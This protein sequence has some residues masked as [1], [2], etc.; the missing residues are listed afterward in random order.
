MIVIG[1]QDFAKVHKALGH[2]PEK[3]R[4]AV[5][6]SINSAVRKGRTTIGKEIRNVYTVSRGR[7]YEGLSMS[8]ASPGNLHGSLVAKGE[9]IPIKEFKVKPKGPQPRSRPVITV[10]I[11][12][13]AAKPFPGGFVIGAFGSHVFTRK[14]RGR[15]PIEKRRSVSV[16]QMMGGDRAG[17]TIRTTIVEHYHKEAGRQ[18]ARALAK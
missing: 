16:P 10:E 14:G 5:S 17:E 15:F 18:V 3:A 4:K 2:I 11:V 8:F 9:G 12:K 13:G 6:M 1:T 7:I